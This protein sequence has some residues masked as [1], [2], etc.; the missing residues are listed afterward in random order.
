MWL[1]E[2]EVNRRRAAAALPVVSGLWLWGGGPVLE[3]LPPSRA[4]AAGDDPLFDAFRASGAAAPADAAV[5][6]VS[7]QPGGE[8]WRELDTRWLEPT[9]AELRVRAVSPSFAFGANRQRTFRLSA[10]GAAPLLAPSAPLVGAFQV[11][12]ARVAEPCA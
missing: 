2:H 10:G 9:V 3:A 4:C 12:A 8:A 6:A 7:A 5:M 11:R 1:F